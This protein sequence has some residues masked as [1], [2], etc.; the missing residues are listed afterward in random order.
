MMIADTDPEFKGI[1][2]A[3]IPTVR[4]RRPRPFGGCGACATKPWPCSSNSAWSP[5]NS[6]SA[7]WSK[8]STWTSPVTPAP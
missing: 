6:R 5:S 3:V 1:C 8:P 2:L 4:P 7:H